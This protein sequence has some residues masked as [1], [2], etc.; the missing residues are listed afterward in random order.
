MRVNTYEQNLFHQSFDLSSVAFQHKRFDVTSEHATAEKL[1]MGKSHFQ[2][3]F[4]QLDHLIQS[5]YGS[6]K[7]RTIFAACELGI[8]D[9]VSS[10]KATADQLI[11]QQPLNCLMR[12]YLWSSWKNTVKKSLTVTPTHKLLSNSW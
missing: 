5:L 12:W 8:F 9:E 3:M 7:L 10:G 11:M 4:V 2:D 1:I 6:F